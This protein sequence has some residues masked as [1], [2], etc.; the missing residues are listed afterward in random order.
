M[1]VG[2]RHAPRASAALPGRPQ[3]R[4]T[5]HARGD[6]R[7]RSERR[8]TSGDRRAT[9]HVHAAGRER[10]RHV[11][12]G[13]R[14]GRVP[15]APR[16]DRRARPGRRGVGQALAVGVRPGARG[17][18]GAHGT[19]RRP[20]R[21]HGPDRVDRHGIVRLRRRHDRPL[22]L[23]ARALT[24]QRAVPAGVPAPDLGRRAEARAH[25]PD[26]PAREGCLPRA[27]GRRVPGQ[28]PDRR[29]LLP[30][31]EPS[32]DEL[33]AARAGHARHGP[34]RADRSRGARRARRVRGG[35]ALRDPRRT[36]NAGW[37]GRAMRC[38]R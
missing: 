26:H 24:E 5:V 19:A 23:A 3:D 28:A 20:L 29:E 37:R 35:D 9:R 17:D 34:G 8:A 10:R 14:G 12:G 2:E 13:G 11:A 7:G 25:A 38:G 36:S 21:R 6:G 33:P 27:E 31:R 18:D 30:A 4:R 15:A 16:P 32:G 1:G 22:R